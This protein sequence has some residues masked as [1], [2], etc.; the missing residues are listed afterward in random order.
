[1]EI[2]TAQLEKIFALIIQKL[3]QE[4]ITKIELDE[5]LY[6]EIPFE[7]FTEIDKPIENMEVG[8]FE[9]DWNIL[10]T[11]LKNGIVLDNN[12]FNRLVNILKAIGLKIDTLCKIQ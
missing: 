9:D 8:S 1:M 6:W 3:N 10:Q 12:D 2:K 4:K 11:S 5:E 7:Q